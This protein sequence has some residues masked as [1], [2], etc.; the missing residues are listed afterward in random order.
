MTARNRR[1][2]T[3]TSTGSS[4]GPE[5]G[6]AAVLC[7]VA[8]ILARWMVDLPGDDGERPGVRV[9][10]PVCALHVDALAALTTLPE[11]DARAALAALAAGMDEAAAALMAAPRADTARAVSV[12]H[13]ALDLASGA[14]RVAVE[15]RRW[16]DG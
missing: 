4:T 6:P 16:S 8:A 7:D 5:W 3:Q 10:A 12:L 9:L 11:R 13:A 1:P 2:S 15:L 14:R